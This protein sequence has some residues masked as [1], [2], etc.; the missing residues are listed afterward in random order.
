MVSTQRWDGLHAIKVYVDESQNVEQGSSGW[1]SKLPM[2]GALGSTPGQ[3]TGFHIRQVRDPV[4]QL[5][6]NTGEI[7]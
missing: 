2:Q 4:V 5:R 1:D 7:N 3:G 6:P